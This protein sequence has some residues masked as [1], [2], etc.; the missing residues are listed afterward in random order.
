[1]TFWHED[2][3][4][5]LSLFQMIKRTLISGHRNLKSHAVL[6]TQ[7]RIIN[8]QMTYLKIAKKFFIFAYN[9]PAKQNVFVQVVE[10]QRNLRKIKPNAHTHV[11]THKSDLLYAV[12]QMHTRNVQGKRKTK[13]G[14][15]MHMMGMYV[16]RNE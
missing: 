9:I 12:R 15:H 2:Q 16:K 8:I 4:S 14:W 1:M 5:S 13:Q 3:K 11:Y 10:E 6:S 7:S